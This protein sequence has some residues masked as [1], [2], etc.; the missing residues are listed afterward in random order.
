MYQR[1]QLI[2]GARIEGPAIVEQRDTT[3]LLA[4]GYASTTDGYGNLIIQPISPSQLLK[5]SP[6]EDQPMSVDP[7]T[8]EIVRGAVS[9]IIRQMEA[10]IET[11]RDVPCNQGED[12]LLR[13]C[14]RP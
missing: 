6:S 11:H 4:A 13:R 2:P 12:G 14:L 3:T 8:L 5:A 7:I 1:D 9:S 10:L